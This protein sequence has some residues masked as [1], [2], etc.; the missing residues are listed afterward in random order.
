VRIILLV[1]GL[2]VLLAMFPVG[3]MLFSNETVLKLDAP[4]TIGVQTP[5]KIRAE[6]SHGVRWITVT[7]E[8][9]G[10]SHETRVAQAKE[11]H[12]F[13]ERHV[14]PKEVTVNVGRQTTPELHDGHPV[15]RMD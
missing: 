5:L 2:V 10:K 13:P 8:Q 1:V 7:V 14:A 15:R 6:N 12:M 4:K 9:D 3:L 11:Q